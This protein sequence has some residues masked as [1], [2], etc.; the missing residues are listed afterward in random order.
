LESDVEARVGKEENGISDSEGKTEIT[1]K[2]FA[3]K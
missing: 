1:D 3:R 2:E